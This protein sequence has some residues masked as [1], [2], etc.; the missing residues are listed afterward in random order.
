MGKSERI[1]AKDEYKIF[2]KLELKARKSPNLGPHGW[3]RIS[4]NGNLHH[5]GSNMVVAQGRYFVSCRLFD[6][7]SSG[8]TPIDQPLAPDFTSYMISHFAIGA[9]GASITAGPPPVAVVSGPTIT[10]TYLEQPI[11]LNAGAGAWLTEPNPAAFTNPYG[12]ANA[13]KAIHEGAGSIVQEQVDHG[14]TLYYTR[15]KCTCVVDDTEP[16]VPGFTTGMT[17]PVSEAG[18][19]ATNGTDTRLFSRI[20]FAPKFLEISSTLTIEWYILC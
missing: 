6:Y 10:D 4:H 16:N 1:F 20:C 7:G 18:L 9:L 5:E 2:D 11:R 17:V 8:W 15:T 13:V 3:V 19:Y 14:G 12:A